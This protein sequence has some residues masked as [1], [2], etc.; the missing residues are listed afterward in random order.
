ME[1][2]Y[3]I[4]ISST[5][6][7]LK[8]ERHELSKLVIE[9]GHIPVDMGQFDIV[10]PGQLAL[11]KKNIEGCDYMLIIIAKKYNLV[12][13]TSI[14]EQ[15]YAHARRHSIPV[16]AMILSDKVKKPASRTE[17]DKEAKK[18]LVVLKEKLKSHP[19][20]SWSNVG[21]L[22]SKVQKLLIRQ[23][24]LAPQLGWIRTNQVID[25]VVA[26]ELGRLSSENS[27]LKLQIKVEDK[28]V[29][30]RLRKRMK[31]TLRL[32]AYNKEAIGFFYVD[33][34]NWENAKNFRYLK[35]F[36]L[37]APELYSGK[38]VSELSKFLGNVLNPDLSK[39]LRKDFPT[40]SNSLKKIITDLRAFRLVKPLDEGS[41]EIWEL[42]EYGKELYSY[43][44]IYQFR[45]AASSGKA[46]K[47]QA[48]SKTKNI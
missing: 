19:Y 13:D 45:R 41:D 39:K 47:T 8:N 34:E 23:M 25:P 29:L 9:L 20:D 38:T 37:L 42:S 32:L 14:V 17:S 28:E 35:L 15:E 4:Y 27:S 31:N 26:N 30:G 36:R 43:Y 3:H 40:P 21:D 2:K 24:N 44:K 22:T 11:I 48:G 18:R 10:D 6:D 1:K 5:L 12:N 46:K 16:L 33:G 7:D